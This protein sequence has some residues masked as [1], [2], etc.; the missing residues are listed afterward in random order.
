VCSKRSLQR[1]ARKNFK[2]QQLID[3][4]YLDEM[5]GGFYDSLWG[6]SAGKG[7]GLGEDEDLIMAEAIS[8]DAR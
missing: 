5:K 8:H 3:R 6:A 1:P 4:K 2:L 7:S